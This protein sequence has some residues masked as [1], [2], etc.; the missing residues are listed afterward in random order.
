MMLSI[1]ELV[2]GVV[3]SIVDNTDTVEIVEEETDSGLLF[4]ITV[5]KDD[6]GKLIGKEGRVASA[7]RTVVKAAGA[8]KGQ[9]VLVNVNN[10][11]LG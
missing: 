8:K 7:L 5:G 2:E 11:P 6:V 10:K 4:T 1:R 9:R 3:S